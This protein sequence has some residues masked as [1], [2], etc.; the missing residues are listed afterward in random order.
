[1]S[2]DPTLPRF[3][4][5]DR[6]E[7]TVLT[8]LTEGADGSREVLFA[9]ERSGDEWV[10]NWLPV[11]AEKFVVTLR[12]HPPRDDDAA[13]HWAAPAAVRLDYPSFVSAFFR[14]RTAWCVRSSFSISAKRTWPSPP[15][16]KPTPGLV[17]TSAF[18]MRNLE[19]SSEFIAR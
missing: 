17:A 1:V 12:P 7:L 15:S 9:Y 16:P 4:R 3:A 13:Q 2:P 19:N 14:L 5:G 11:P 10:S 6:D 8:G 18:S